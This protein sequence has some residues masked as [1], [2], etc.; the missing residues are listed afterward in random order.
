ME[1]KSSSSLNYAILMKKLEVVKHQISL[2]VDVNKS[3]GGYFPLFTAFHGN[4]INIM[5][6]LIENGAD[7]TCC[8]QRGISLLQN[9]LLLDKFD[10][11][12][13]LLRNGADTKS[14]PEINAF[15]SK[16]MIDILIERAPNFNIAETNF[17]TVFQFAIYH[18]EEMALKILE[19]LTA[20]DLNIINPTG[21]TLLN[22]ALEFRRRKVV[23]K[24]VEMGADI[25]VSDPNSTNPLLEAVIHN[26]LEIVR[27]FL[28]HGASPNVTGVFNVP[29]IEAVINGNFDMVKLLL[30]R[31]ANANETDFEGR[32]S[33]DWACYP[34]YRKQTEIFEYIDLFE[35]K[36]D[37]EYIICNSNEME[38]NYYKIIQILTNSGASINMQDLCGSTALHKACERKN[39]QIVQ[40]LLKREINLEPYC[41]ERCSFFHSQSKDVWDI[42]ELKLSSDIPMEKN[43]DRNSFYFMETR[44]LLAHLRQLFLLLENDI[45]VNIR[46]SVGR[47]PLY[48]AAKNGC[49]EIIKN[50]LKYQADVDLSDQYYD[51]SA[52]HVALHY[53]YRKHE[54]FDL[55]PAKRI[56]EK[57][58]I[59]EAK[60]QYVSKE[61][62]NLINGDL[63]SNYYAECKTEITKMKKKITDESYICYY[64]FLS[65]DI[66]K[67]A[68]IAKNP[69]V[70]LRMKSGEYKKAFPIYEYLLE[71][72]VHLAELRKMLIQVSEITF[73]HLMITKKLPK[74][75]ISIIEDMLDY[76]GDED[77]LHFIEAAI[78]E[79]YL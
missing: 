9:A 60:E 37:D 39:L 57:I 32:S 35:F 56:V 6:L 30:E 26:D 63:L 18:N 58:A 61:D 7:V 28:D 46:D 14:H 3:I 67:F 64:D 21:Q 34:I 68:K 77:L 20:I 62:L 13:L 33:L 78:P 15:E 4:D 23:Q 66:K 45:N 50:L 75:P 65:N 22:T 47:T 79:R 31:G 44:F 71:R 29:L 40:L 41:D 43:K 51:R 53:Y 54:Y 73:Q 12:K 25:T 8:D 70:M 2:G 11:V 69:S 38:E 42:T 55:E 72:T 59:K 74:I 52:L 19:K 49:S 27:L 1:T 76:L 24:M 36:Y 5:K 17:P 48:F 16:N 10:V